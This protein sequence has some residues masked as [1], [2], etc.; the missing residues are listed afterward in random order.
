MLN[1][2]EYFARRAGEERLAAFKSETMIVRLRHLEFAQAYELRTREL[3]A[4]QRRSAFQV[5]DGPRSA[6]A[7]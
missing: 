4:L 6:S 3:V 2:A 7:A 5:I 1:D